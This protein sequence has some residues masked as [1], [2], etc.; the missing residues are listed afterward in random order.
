MP[1]LEIDQYIDNWVLVSALSDIVQSVLTESVCVGTH[2]FN[3]SNGYSQL[4]IRLQISRR[5]IRGTAQYRVIREDA[6][7]LLFPGE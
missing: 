3:K 2:H 6:P 4:S 5:D 7:E 1:F